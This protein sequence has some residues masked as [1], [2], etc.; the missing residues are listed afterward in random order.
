[1][2]I[3]S[4]LAQLRL[5]VTVVHDGQQA[6]AAVHTGVVFDVILMDLQI[7]MQDD[8]Q[9]TAEIRQ[10]EAAQQRPRLPILAPTA[11]GFEEDCQ[12]CV[13]A[14]VN[15]FLTRP[16]ALNALKTALSR[17]LPAN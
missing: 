5:Q 7:P 10:W 1:M 16:I 4:L 13:A 15:D 12:N 8:Y 11:D 17:W 3:A 9:A 14:G 6:V 2:V